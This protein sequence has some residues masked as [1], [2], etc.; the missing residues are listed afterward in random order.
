MQD[1]YPLQQGIDQLRTAP[2]GKGEDDATG[3]GDSQVHPGDAARA[4]I[5]R[6]HV[7]KAAHGTNQGN[8]GTPII[9]GVQLEDTPIGVFFVKPPGTR[10]EILP[11]SLG[12]TSNIHNVAPLF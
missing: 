11:E 10:F 12:R 2:K 6:Q 4:A 1:Y 7:N 8:Q 3:S 9:R 5:G